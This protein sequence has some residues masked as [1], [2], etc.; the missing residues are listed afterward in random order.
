MLLGH[1]LC[2]GYPCTDGLTRLLGKLKLDQSLSF[3]LQDH[4]SRN[5]PTALGYI[6]NPQAHQITSP[7][8]AVYCQVE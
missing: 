7:K 1:K 8:L 5:N 4:R 6:T 3:A 2:P